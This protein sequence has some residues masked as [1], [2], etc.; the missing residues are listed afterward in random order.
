MQ[1]NKTSLNKLLTKR[2]KIDAPGF[3][4]FENTIIPE[5]YPRLKDLSMKHIAD[6]VFSDYVRI[7]DANKYWMVKCV[8]CDRR[9]FREDATKINNGHYKTRANYRYRYDIINCHPQC[10][11]CNVVH[12]WNYREY[13]IYMVD[14]YGEDVERQL[15]EDN[16][17]TKLYDY[18][19]IMQCVNRHHTITEKKLIIQ[20][21][22]PEKLYIKP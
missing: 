9:Y 4:Y 21:N 6:R 2:R 5:Y 10:Y 17:I 3:D 8:T 15:R 18:D 16:S 13:Y 19:L 22:N 14:N 11:T 20:E 12:S 7:V 1:K